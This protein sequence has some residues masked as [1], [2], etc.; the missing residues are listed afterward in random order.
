MVRFERSKGRKSNSDFRDESPKRF[1]R[2]RPSFEDS[3]RGSGRRFSG[4]DSTRDGGNRREFN[5]TK[6]T[7]SSCGNECEVPFKPTSSKPVFCSDCF[8]K[9]EKGGSNKPSNRD[10]DIINEKLD[11]IMDALDIK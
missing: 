11:K 8:S 5:M 10:F 4:R 2:N 1:T 6:V 9:K 7:C 3:P